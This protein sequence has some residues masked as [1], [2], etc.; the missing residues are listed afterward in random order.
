MM[1]I[2][3]CGSRQARSDAV[4]AA[5]EMAAAKNRGPRPRV[6]ANVEAGLNAAVKVPAGATAGEIAMGGAPFAG[7][8]N[9]AARW[10]GRFGISK[11]FAGR[12]HYGER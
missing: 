3:R 6:Q 11:G 9:H 8:G 10:M 1:K 4:P 12:L 7:H 5:K 2:G